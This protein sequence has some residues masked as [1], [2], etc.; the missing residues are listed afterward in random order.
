ML[1]NAGLKGVVEAEVRKQRRQGQPE[2][3]PRPRQLIA[4]TSQSHFVWH[5]Q[6]LA[7]A[8]WTL[9]TPRRL[10]LLQVLLA[11]ARQVEVSL[12]LLRCLLAAFSVFFFLIEFFK[13]PVVS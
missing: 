5:L 7:T 10:G 9:S 1:H 11:G 4:T 2:I 8:D 6:H 13:A 3:E 12:R